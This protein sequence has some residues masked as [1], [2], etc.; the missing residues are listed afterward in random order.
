MRRLGAGAGTIVS[1]GNGADQ[2][3]PAG[4]QLT[5]QTV[6]RIDLGRRDPSPGELEHCCPNGR[7][8]SGIGPR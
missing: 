3:L 6:D 5:V 4:T 8:L 7:P 2:T 1:L